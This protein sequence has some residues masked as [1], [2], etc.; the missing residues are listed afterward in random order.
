MYSSLSF[1]IRIISLTLQ[2]STEIFPFFCYYLI[3]QLRKPGHREVNNL[4]KMSHLE[5]GK[6]IFTQKI[7]GGIIINLYSSVMY[8]YNFYTNSEGQLALPIFGFGFK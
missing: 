7:V 3:I 8:L 1:L 5:G 2:N 6:L 4:P